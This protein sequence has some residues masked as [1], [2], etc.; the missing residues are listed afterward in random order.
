MS[1]AI[2]L[3][4]WRYLLDCVSDASDQVVT[5]KLNNITLI[6]INRPESRNAVN[7]QTAQQ[8]K[9]AFLNFDKDKYAH[10]AILY[11]KGN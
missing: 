8:L 6:A 11:G 9:Q 3:L 10:V 5:E 7:R 2:I 4:G 1:F